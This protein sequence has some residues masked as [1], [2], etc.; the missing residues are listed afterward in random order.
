MQVQEISKKM[1]LARP[2]LR[3]I[4]REHLRRP[5]TGPVLT[6]G[7]QNVYST[8]MDA[9]KLLREEGISPGPLADGQGTCTNIPSWVNTPH[10][11]NTSDVAFFRMLGVDEV[12]ALDCSDFE[13]ADILHDMNQRVPDRLRDRFGLVVDSGTLEHIFDVRQAL[14]NIAFMVKPG[15]RVIHLAPANNC[16]N[17]GFYQFSPTLFY[18]FYAANMFRDIRGLLAEHHINFHNT[19]PWEVYEVGVWGRFASRQV[20]TTIFVAEKTN[21]STCD[22]IPVQSFYSRSPSVSVAEVDSQEDKHPCSVERKEA[23]SPL[24]RSIATA[25]KRMCPC[26][27]ALKR[28][29]S[30]PGLDPTRKPWGLKKWGVLRP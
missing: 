1:G 3:F 16:V 15:G 29:L 21:E 27:V 13:G 26:L 6:L 4:A 22:G 12:L 18:D 11:S 2:V 9:Q 23:L 28:W 8:L 5:F 20:L 24:I 19:L 17:H 25:V 14:S 30:L 10:E 7:R